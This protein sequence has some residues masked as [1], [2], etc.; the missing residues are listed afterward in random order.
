MPAYPT[1]GGLGAPHL[2]ETNVRR[3]PVSDRERH[4]VSGNQVSRKQMLPLPFSYAAL[5]MVKSKITHVGILFLCTLINLSKDYRNTLS[6][7][8]MGAPL[9]FCGSVIF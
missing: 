7:S 5:G 3:D 6:L 9:C 1:D 2:G 4:D 8:G